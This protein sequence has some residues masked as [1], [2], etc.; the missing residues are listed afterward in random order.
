MWKKDYDRV[1][2]LAKG[3]L[4]STTV[5][6]I[7]AESLYILARV[8]HVRDEMEKAHTFYER[9]CNLA[10]DLSP[11]RFGLAQT[12]I[13]DETY[14]EAAGHLQ[15]VVGKSPSAT[16]AHATLGLLGVKSGKDRKG[17]FSNIK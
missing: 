13:W 6:G 1:I 5:Q 3:A 2:A 15:L 14:D 10:P 11:A 12:L 16:D 8:H 4:S 9:A 17:A 7:Q